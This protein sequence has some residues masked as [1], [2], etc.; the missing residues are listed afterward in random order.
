VLQGV[1]FDFDGVLANSEPLHLQAFQAVLGEEDL[2]LSAQEYYERYVGFDDEE[3]FSRIAH[4]NGIDDAPAWT[5]RLIARKSA[6]MQ[7]LLSRT[8]TL[9]P[10]AAES[11]RALAA[12][13]PIAIASGAIREEILQVLDDA[14]LTDAFAAIVAAGETRRGKPAADP[15]QRAVELMSLACGTW[16]DPPT[17]VAI[18]D[19]AQG[20]VAARAA[21]LRT[22]G[23]TTTYKT[24]E[25]GLADLVLPG[26]GAVT[27]E[28]LSSLCAKDGRR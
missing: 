10:G 23:L 24:F 18:E 4:A 20:L 21:G 16:L 17:V 5:R 11:V 26:I 13:L 19:S 12:R 2:A 1:V 8:S 15:Y 28:Q 22:V 6:R 7:D 27:F 14:E 3:V 25:T 9:F